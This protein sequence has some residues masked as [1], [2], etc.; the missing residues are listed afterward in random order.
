MVSLSTVKVVL[1]LNLLAVIKLDCVEYKRDLTSL[2]TTFNSDFEGQLLSSETELEV[3][4][5][6]SM[7][8]RLKLFLMSLLA[9][10]V[11]RELSSLAL[12]APLFFLNFEEP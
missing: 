9:F 6:Y 2:V 8:E 5:T 3:S 11:I 12:L 7:L 10:L 4:E 1:T